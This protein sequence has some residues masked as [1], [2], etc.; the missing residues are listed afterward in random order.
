MLPLESISVLSISY[1]GIALLGFLPTRVPDITNPFSST[2]LVTTSV[3][4]VVGEV[5]FLL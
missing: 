3:V 1:P 2:N 4:G 5:V